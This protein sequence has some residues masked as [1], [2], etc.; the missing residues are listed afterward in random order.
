MA[1]L[2]SGQEFQKR[3]VENVTLLWALREIP[4]ISK[5]NNLRQDGSGRRQLPLDREKQL[6]D[7]FAFIAAS[8]EDSL[9]VMAVCIEED[10]DQN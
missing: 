3:L 9:R 1:K 8:T 4:E 7:L 6:V 2:S 5:E 10:S